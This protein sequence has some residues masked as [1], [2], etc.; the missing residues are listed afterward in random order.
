[1]LNPTAFGYGHFSFSWGDHICAIF[2]SHAQQM[3]IMG[4]FIGTGLRAS[5]R[6]VWVAPEGSAN[7]LRGALADMGGDLPTLESSSQLL[8]ISE[9]EFYLHE[10]IFEPSR[11][12]DLLKALLD[13]NQREGYDTMR[14]ASDVSWL[15]DDCPD[16]R[17]WEEF[18]ARLTHEIANLPLVMV[19]QYDWRQIPGSL[20]LTA[21]RTHPTVILGDTFRRNPFYIAEPLGASGPP[22]IV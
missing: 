1:V 5:Q 12:M 2:D 6:C 8:I 18:E 7:A 16:L 10:G 9:V 21:L 11:I 22:E 13:D 17:L 3:E 14:I 15:R 4:G 19:C 20:I